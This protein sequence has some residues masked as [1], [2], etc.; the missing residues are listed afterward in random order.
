MLPCSRFAY[1]HR[2]NPIYFGSYCSHDSCY[3]TP[4]HSEWGKIIH[5]FF[6]FISAPEFYNPSSWQGRK[7]SFSHR[8]RAAHC[9]SQCQGTWSPVHGPVSNY[10]CNLAAQ[11]FHCWLQVL[12]ALKLFF[13]ICWTGIYILLLPKVLDQMQ[14]VDYDQLHICIHRCHNELYSYLITCIDL[15]K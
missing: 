4:Q 12:L 6:F 13:K 1:I 11:R 15:L 10:P 5:L 2:Q 7:K 3:L 8:A 14:R 9:S